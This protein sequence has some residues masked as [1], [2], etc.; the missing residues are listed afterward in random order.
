MSSS[1]RVSRDTELRTSHDSGPAFAGT[2]QFVDRETI[3]ILRD[4]ARVGTVCVHFPRVGYRVTV[5][6]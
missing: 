5:A 2:I 1:A 6:A 3:A 4:D